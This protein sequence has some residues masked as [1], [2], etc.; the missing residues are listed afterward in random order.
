MAHPLRHEFDSSPPGP[1]FFFVAP[2]Y[3]AGRDPSLDDMGIVPG[4]PCLQARLAFTLV[5]VPGLLVGREK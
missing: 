2:H 3:E 4:V 5:E 1:H